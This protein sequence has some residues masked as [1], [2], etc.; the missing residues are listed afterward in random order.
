MLS[1]TE[2]GLTHAKGSSPMGQAKSNNANG[3]NR[4]DVETGDRMFVPSHGC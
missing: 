2:R 4:F 1:S 3:Y